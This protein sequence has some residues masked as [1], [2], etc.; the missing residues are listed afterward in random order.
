VKLFSCASTVLVVV[1]FCLFAYI[2]CLLPFLNEDMLPSLAKTD[3]DD[4]VMIS[5]THTT[6]KMCNFNNFI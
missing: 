3:D 5:D 6:L 2:C 1:I 4:N